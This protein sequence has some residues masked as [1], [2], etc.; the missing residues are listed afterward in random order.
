MGLGASRWRWQGYGAAILAVAAAAAV[1]AVLLGALETRTPWLTFYPAVMIA[2]LY[3]GFAA[4]LLATVLTCLAIVFGWPAFGHQPFIVASADWLGTF[5]F[6][7]NGVMISIIAEAMR[8]ARARAKRAEEE[9]VAANLAKSEFLS[10]MSHE[11]RTPLNAI[12]GF[13]QL[14]ELDSLTPE[15][16]ENVSY[17]AKAG[18]HLL[19]LIDEILDISRI[20]SG[21][22]TISPEPVAV[23]DLLTELAALVGPLAD[24]RK[25]SLDATDATCS[26][27][28]LADRQRLRQVLLNLLSNAVKYNREGG[29]VAVRCGPVG[30]DRMRI[31]VIDTGY[32]IAPE[33][34]DRLFRPFERLGAEQGAIEGTGM[35]LALSKGL[36]EAMGGSI[37]VDT[38]LDVGSTFWV[39]L[40]LVEGPVERYERTRVV[41]GESPVERP[42]RVVLQIE[43]NLSNQKLVERIVSLRPS[44]ELM[45]AMQGRLGIELAREHR[46]DLILLDL[47]LPDLAG[48]EVLRLL[49]AHP[50]TWA[51]PVV[52]VSADATRAQ[53]KRMGEAGV[54]GYLTKPLDVAE[55]LAV[56]DRA[57]GVD[58]PGTGP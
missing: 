25:V 53:V 35:G 44:Y 29:S 16:A 31:A 17:I 37:G 33:H 13:S 45:T 56:L 32:G 38:T 2:G 21:R 1:R 48:H 5:V 55:F 42:R 43:D 20:E 47:H 15:Q 12:L 11:L 41:G 14:L 18:R 57:V 9:A 24:G 34:L 30:A 28:V 26:S 4:G 54:F 49:K 27:H 46:P 22:I 7:F 3:G 8:R 6:V 39:E 51:I 10:R 58:D 50:D 52:V 40:G 19:E 23:G 36:V